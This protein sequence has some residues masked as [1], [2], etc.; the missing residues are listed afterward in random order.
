MKVCCCTYYSPSH[1]ALADIHLPNLSEYCHRHG[2][3]MWVENI[4]NDKWEYKKHEMFTEL[5]EKGFDVIWYRDI[6]SL[7]TNLTIPV[8][9]FIKE[10][11]DFFLTMDFTELN[12]GSVIIKNTSAGKRFNDLILSLRGRYEN[13]QNCYNALE[14]D[15]A[16]YSIE[17]LPQQT[18][19]SYRYE[20]YKEIGKLSPLDGQWEEGHFVLHTP[21]LPFKKRVEVL[22]NAK[23]TR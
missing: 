9:V 5:F 16:D 18:I 3:Y 6:D 13:E 14:S 4:E 2:Y 1:Q 10:Y 17:V 20:E 15:D 21:G 7:I 12:G 8:T 22:K 19:N 11:R 23:L